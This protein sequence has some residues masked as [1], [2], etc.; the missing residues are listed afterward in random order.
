MGGRGASSSNSMNVPYDKWGKMVDEHI[1][2][3]DGAMIGYIEDREVFEY[4]P[5]VEAIT[6]KQALQ[7]VDDWRMDDGTYGDKD[8]AIYFAYQD[9]T[10]VD[11]ADL[12]GKAYKKTGLIG[13]SLSGADDEFVWGG[14]MYKGEF[15][16]WKTWSEDGESGHSNSHAYHK[17]VGVYKIRTKVITQPYQTKSGDTQYRTVRTKIRQSQVKKF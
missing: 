3:K 16:A 14:E 12:N 5:V 6:K 9:G 13:V 2:D 17:A 7:A 11:A 15:R 10:F 1:Y 8:T 4:E